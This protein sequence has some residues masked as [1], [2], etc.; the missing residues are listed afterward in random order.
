M[1]FQEKWKTTLLTKE[2]DVYTN[3]AT[4]TAKWKK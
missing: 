3:A 4:R 2:S 1:Q